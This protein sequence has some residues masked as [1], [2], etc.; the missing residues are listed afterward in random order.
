MGTTGLSMGRNGLMDGMDG[1]WNLMRVK[2]TM[3]EFQIL[4]FRYNQ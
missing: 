4:Q 3:W 2:V 1:V